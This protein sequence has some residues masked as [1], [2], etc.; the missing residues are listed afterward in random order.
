MASVKFVPVDSKYVDLSFEAG[1]L[2]GFDGYDDDMQ[3]AWGWT[4]AAVLSGKF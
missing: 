2:V 1:P 3:F 4:G